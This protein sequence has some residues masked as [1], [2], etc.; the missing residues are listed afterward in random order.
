MD[1]LL[2]SF[3]CL[4]RSAGSRGG[5]T[6]HS[7][8]PRCAAHIE[9]S[10]ALAPAAGQG[11]KSER[12]LWGDPERNGSLSFYRAACPGE[13]DFNSALTRGP[14][15]DQIMC[16]CGRTLGVVVCGLFVS[17]GRSKVEVLCHCC[18]VSKNNRV[19]WGQVSTALHS[20]RKLFF[21]SNFNRLHSE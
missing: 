20:N 21:L 8:H 4:C 5:R 12:Q 9:V 19:G 11:H 10:S 1:W 7:P 2:S 6:F 3:D 18:L 16:T 14:P 17:L 15:K 13:G